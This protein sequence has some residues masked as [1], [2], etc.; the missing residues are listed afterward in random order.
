MPKRKN[1]ISSGTPGNGPASALLFLFPLFLVFFIGWSGDFLPAVLS[2][3]SPHW[4]AQAL[5]IILLLALVNMALA[6]RISSQRST[7]FK[8]FSLFILLAS[9]VAGLLGAL[10]L[11]ALGAGAALAC[12]SILAEKG[13][14]F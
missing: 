5:D 13:R 12:Y 1:E 9:A 10:D 14:V 8:W 2:A 7:P 3:S 6:V 4:L 11:A